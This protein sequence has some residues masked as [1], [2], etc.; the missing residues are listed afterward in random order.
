MDSDGCEVRLV[1]ARQIIAVVCENELYAT[2]AIV[3][4]NYDGETFKVLKTGLPT[5]DRVQLSI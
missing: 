1:F 5:H 2:I 3:N 4:L